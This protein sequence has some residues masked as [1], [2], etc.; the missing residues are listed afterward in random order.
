VA[1]DE[2]RRLGDRR[3]VDF[4]AVPPLL[5]PRADRIDYCKGGNGYRHAHAGRVDAKAVLLRQTPPVPQPHAMPEPGAPPGVGVVLRRL[6]TRRGRMLG[7]AGHATERRRKRRKAEAGGDLYYPTVPRR[8]NLRGI[9]RADSRIPTRESCD[10]SRGS[11]AINLIPDFQLQF[12][13]SNLQFQISK[14]RIFNLRLPASLLP[15][16]AARDLPP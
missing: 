13:I 7:D 16:T 8:R 1:E 15:R 3:V 12:T 4:L 14:P 9:W 5:K 10:G 2:D 11:A 6:G